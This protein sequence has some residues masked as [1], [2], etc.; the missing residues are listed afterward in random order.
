M[1]SVHIVTNLLFWISHRNSFSRKTSK[2]LLSSSMP[3]KECSP[4]PGR[5]LQHSESALD[6][7]HMCCRKSLFQRALEWREWTL[8]IHSVPCITLDH[9]IPRHLTAHRRGFVCRP[10]SAN[11]NKNTGKNICL[12]TLMIGNLSFTPQSSAPCLTYLHIYGHIISRDEARN[13]YNLSWAE[14]SYPQTIK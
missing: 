8:D 12:C 3:F 13:E 6:V 7:M 5:P 4:I 1:T 2:N 14:S 11:K 9:S 10:S